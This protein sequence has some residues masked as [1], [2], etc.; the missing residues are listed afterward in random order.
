MA[1]RLARRCTV[2]LTHIVSIAFQL[3]SHD[4]PKA[5]ECAADLGYVSTSGNT[6]VSPLNL[7]VVRSDNLP[8]TVRKKNDRVVTSGLAFNW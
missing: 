1:A 2:A 4:K 8:E 7:S 5:R 6:E 3:Q